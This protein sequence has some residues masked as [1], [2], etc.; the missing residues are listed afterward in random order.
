MS[1]EMNQEG[2]FRVQITEYYL[3]EKESGSV[4]IVADANVLDRWIPPTD[5]DDGCWEPWQQHNVVVRGSFYIVGTTAKGGKLNDK[6]IESLIQFC[7]WDGNMQSIH[8]GSWTPSP[9]RMS[10]EDNTYEG[11][12]TYRMGWPSDFNSTPGGQRLDDAAM[13]RIESKHA[14]SLRAIAGNVKRNTVPTTDKPAPAPAVQQPAASPPQQSVA[15][16]DDI[17][18]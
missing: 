11:K 14:S 17:P 16:A 3:S 12:T 1:V 15:P 5:V 10:I 9:C 4:A 18:F 7:G 8:A 2:D 6:L 13:K